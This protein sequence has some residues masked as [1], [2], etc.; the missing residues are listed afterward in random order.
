MTVVGVLVEA[1]VGHEH[2]LVTDF[3]AEIPQRDLHDAVGMVG[4]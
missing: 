2:E 4:L 3:V 1:V